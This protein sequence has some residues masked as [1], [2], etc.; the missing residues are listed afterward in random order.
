MFKVTLLIAGLAAAGQQPAPNPEAERASVHGRMSA[1]GFVPLEEM[2]FGGREV[3]RILPIDPYGGLPI[4]GIEIERHNEGRVTLRAQYR[5]YTG[6]V[7]DVSTTE[8]DQLAALEK[9]A[10]GPP[11]KNSFIGRPGVAVHCWSGMVEASP[12]KAA[13][14]WGC[15]DGT[16]ATQRYTEAVLELALSKK[17][18]PPNEKNVLWQFDDC[19]R[20][21]EILRDSVLNARFAALREDWTKQRELVPDLLGKARQAL[22]A[23]E[24]EGTV[25]NLDAAQE[26]VLAYGQRQ[27]A[28]RRIRDSGNRS[29]PYGSVVDPRTQTIISQTQRYWNEVLSNSKGTYVELLE[30]LAKL[31]ARG[32]ESQ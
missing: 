4:P 9:A 16:L 11:G 2:T 29:L 30:Q 7:Y 28:L 25:H 12:A 19:F 23:A 32:P 1:S 17:G 27:K 10:L 26:A 5:G 24:A 18:C 22:Q 20:D 13:T 8:W 6:D 14:W 31:L 3:R 21:S 15:N